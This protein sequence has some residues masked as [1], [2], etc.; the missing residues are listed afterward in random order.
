MNL[1]TVIPKK[2][3]EDVMISDRNE[4]DSGRNSC[5]KHNLTI[6]AVFT[7]IFLILILALMSPGGAYAQTGTVSGVVTD[8]QTEETLP[9]ANVVIQ[10]TNIGVST[11]V[12]GRYT[13]RRVPVGEHVLSISYM[14]YQEQVIDITVEDGE[15]LELNFA[16]QVAYIEGTEV[17][18]VGIQR[19]QS[20]ALTRQRQSINIREVVSSDQID[21]FSDQ[22]VEGALQRVA[23]MGHGGTANIRGV[24]A[25]MSR[26]TMDGQRMG[27]T[28]ADRSVDLS[29]ISAD[30][31][32][33]LDVIKVITP[34]M[35]ADA[36]SGVI[37][38]ST[39]R[40]IGGERTMNVRG[41]G[42]YQPRYGGHT[43]PGYRMSLSYGDSPDDSYSYGLNFSFQREPR[44][45]ESFNTSWATRNI[46]GFGMT[47]VLNA[48]TAR[49]DFQTRDRYGA[50]GQFTFQPTQR[51]TYHFQGLFNYQDRFENRYGQT[52]S[53][54]IQSYV[55]PTQTGP[56]D[57]PGA[58]TIGFDTR[59]REYSIYQATLQAG[60]RHLFDSFDMEYKIGWGHGRNHR[61]QYSMNWGHGRPGLDFF[62]D[63]SDRWHPTLEIASH[64]PSTEFPSNARVS[65][66]E[67]LTHTV[68]IH[69]DNEITATIDF[70]VPY[71]LGSFEFG[72]G[73]LSTFQRGN[74]EVFDMNY[75]GNFGP[76]SFTQLIN[77]T[78]NVMGRNHWNYQ[79][80]Y[81]MDGRKFIE[82]YNNR[83]PHLR[84]DV[85]EYAE[86][87]SEYFDG[88]ENVFSAYAMTKFTYSMFTLLG[89]VRVEHTYAN[90]EAREGVFSSAEFFEGSIPIEASVNYTNVFP[91]A[92]LIIRLTDFTNIRAAYS[93]SI[94]RP[95]FNQLS[96]YRQW[97][98]HSR[99][100]EHGN[101]NLKPMVSNNYDL[102]FEHYFRNV[103]QFSIGFFYKQLDD[104]VFLERRRIQQEGLT[105]LDRLPRG[106][107]LT[108]VGWDRI[109]YRNGE[110]ADIY[111]VEVSWQQTLSFLPGFLSYLGTYANFTYT[112]SEADIGRLNDAGESVY[113]Q[114]QNQRPHVVNAG[115]DYT[116]GRFI[117]QISYQ[118]S[119][120]FVSSYAATRDWVPTIQLQERVYRDSYTDGANDLS[121]TL[122]Y[123]I[124]DNI[125]IW[126][127]GANLTNSRTINYIYD[128]DFFPTSQS[129]RGTEITL[130]IQINL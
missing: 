119:D 62:V 32:Q 128:Q 11:D 4:M 53:P 24:G 86:S 79:I 81:M 112:H 99:T 93:K 67:F 18:V 23:G 52:I 120:P 126:M 65:G 60:A 70:D 48:L 111:G 43:G 57:H 38:I 92:Q 106:G 83:R 63:I 25:G 40:P 35:S 42:G 88:N 9:G 51:T 101:P 44:G 3:F 66:A 85:D 122:R 74:E 49:Y 90:Y 36:L 58:G 82:Q 97:N 41:G 127:N 46:A 72:G 104:F 2:Q 15:R 26:V 27:S 130:G 117:G 121:L 28:D 7:G 55:S 33:E 95:R 54:R 129:L 73:A 6:H 71:S 69:T 56:D 109:T 10:G 102:L 77:N 124:T 91:N 116:R 113:V 50:G 118:W 20:R 96:P 68:N 125:R 21:R 78:W 39:R 100:V 64:G 5:F 107:P 16:L 108:Y 89:G 14:G 76:G 45:E 30:M 47:D 105:D 80:P 22:T 123:G 94:G 87:E 17:M 37:N 34:N 103:G 59:F 98:F 31:V 29:T 12:D 61:N 75:G 19:G 13:L 115:L 110:E 8:A 1:Y 114:L 84:M